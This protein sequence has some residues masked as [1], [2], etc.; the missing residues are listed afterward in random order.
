[1]NPIITIALKEFKDGLRNRWMLAITLVFALFSLGLSFLGSAA[2]GTLGF[3]SLSSTLVSLS[4]LA[5]IL[6][7]LIALLVSY[8]AFVG[9]YEQGT[10]L[11]LLTY[12]VKRSQILL[13]KF[14]GQGG[15]LAVASL[16]GFG[17]AALAIFFTTDL[18]GHAILK[19]FSG[20]ILSAILLG[21]IFIALA[22]VISL[23]VSEKSTAAGLALLVWFLF[24]LVF[25]LL[26][27]AVLVATEGKL[28]ADLLSG[29]LLL[30]PT[31]VFRLINYQL[32]DPQ[33]L[34]NYGGA[35]QVLQEA[36]PSKASLF[37]IL[38]A[39]LLAPLGLAGWIFQKRSI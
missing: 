36:P 34:A 11:L 38:L 21:W 17:S 4:S 26:L 23:S 1:M 35:L 20:F 24:V 2:S 5:V 29:L 30:N 14:I 32:A 3:A 22:Y 8:Q 39:W 9:E 10:L 27:L 19:A 6:I 31:D 16:A 28:N 33:G 25:D 12:P 37:L 15:I 13:G 18:D 7:P